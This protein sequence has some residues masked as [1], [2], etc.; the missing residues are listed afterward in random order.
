MI[1]REKQPS[2]D[3]D[4]IFTPNHQLHISKLRHELSMTTTE[5]VPL[6]PSQQV[7]TKKKNA[8]NELSRP[9]HFNTK[10][11][12]NRQQWMD[13]L[14]QA[15]SSMSTN[16]HGSTLT[17][18]DPAMNAHR[19]GMSLDETRVSTGL[20]GVG[21]AQNSIHD[22]ATAT[23]TSSNS[24]YHRRVLS[25]NNNNYY[26]PHQ[27]QTGQSLYQYPYA[28]GP[29]PPL[30]QSVNAVGFGNGSSASAVG[31]TN[32]NKS[33]LP[34]VKFVNSTVEALEDQIRK[35]D[36]PKKKRT[37]TTPEQLR[38]L[39]KAFNSDPMP[40]SGTRVALAKKLGMNARAVQVW[41]QNRRAK[42]KLEAKRAESGGRS[43][44]ADSPQPPYMNDDYLD[45]DLDQGVD[46]YMG[47]EDD[48]MEFENID[49][50]HLI[51]DRHVVNN[52]SYRS[53]NKTLKA[54]GM[55]GRMAFPADLEYLNSGPSCPPY[56]PYFAYNTNTNHQ[57][58]QSLNQ[59]P[60]QGHHSQLSRS[61]SLPYLESV[62]EFGA[63]L[64]PTLL[65][66][67]VLSGDDES[68]LCTLDSA[69]LMSRSDSA[70]FA[71]YEFA[72]GS[73]AAVPMIPDGIGNRPMMM[74]ANS[75]SRC[76][77]LPSVDQYDPN[78]GLV[79]LLPPMDDPVWPTISI[80]DP[81]HN[82]QQ[83]QQQNQT[84]TH[85]LRRSFSLPNVYHPDYYPQMMYEDV[86]TNTHLHPQPISNQEPD[87]SSRSQSPDYLPA[88]DT[89]DLTT[90][91]PHSTLHRRTRSHSISHNPDYPENLNDFLTGEV[92]QFD[93]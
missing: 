53:T 60:P 76:Q 6:P 61:F 70:S 35:E 15:T 86:N 67:S 63:V 26:P 58:Q 2:I 73:G 36:A 34:E 89:I 11:T 62:R 17:T 16:G 28:S 9:P 68:T 31:N 85:H 47:N 56:P 27:Q 20:V 8:L 83:Q 65:G 3:K 39:Q 66:Q 92:G 78:A 10:P 51:S 1:R 74:M 18:I 82:Q 30:S 57:Y 46:D 5:D 91:P 12:D 71:P 69:G 40:N 48:P 42:A 81:Y 45:D 19:R 44:G 14:L 72:S 87:L 79:D 52:P 90:P 41:F 33:L 37:R 93:D 75:N 49:G 29:L 55:M 88:I 38:I 22:S 50:N 43:S 77:S 84:N 59:R 25:H 21:A 4:K 7:N 32:N 23:A 80:P 24:Q 64:D 13:G 54:T